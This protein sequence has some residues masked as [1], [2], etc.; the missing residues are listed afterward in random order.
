MDFTVF[1]FIHL[2]FPTRH[3]GDIY[4]SRDLALMA[5]TEAPFVDKLT[6]ETTESMNWQ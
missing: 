5:I 1:P 4:L 6:C 3:V 2:R